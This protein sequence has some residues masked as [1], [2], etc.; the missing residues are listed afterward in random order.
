MSQRLHRTSVLA[1][2]SAALILA[3]GMGFGRF[4]FTGLYPLM[5]R[6]GLLTVRTGSLAASANYAGYLIGALL[7][8]RAAD[9]HAARLCKW[10]LAG[11]L[12]CLAVLAVPQPAWAILPVR[13]LAGIF[14][15][16]GMI[17]ASVWLLQRMQQQHGAPL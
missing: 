13:L 3:I 4:A 8:S 7:L 15:A 17:G 9:H 10:A 2:L 5:V 16:V 11:T 12:V 1:A 6:D 14:S